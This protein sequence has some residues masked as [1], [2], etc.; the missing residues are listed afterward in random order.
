MGQKNRYQF[1]AHGGPLGPVRLVVSVPVK[2][3][4]LLGPQFA[5]VHYKRIWLVLQQ[6]LSGVNGVMVVHSVHVIQQ[7]ASEPDQNH[8]WPDHQHVTEIWSKK[9]CALLV[10]VPLFT[11]K[12]VLR[13]N[14]VMDIL[15]NQ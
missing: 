9:K 12:Y 5:M 15:R 4:V 3:H 1:G 2:P 7:R 6:I 13:N 8:V 14:Y 11:I 10:L